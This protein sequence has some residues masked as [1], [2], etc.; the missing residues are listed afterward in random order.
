[1]TEATKTQ[2]YYQRNKK[3]YQKGGKY[4]KYQPVE[5]RTPKIP[6]VVKKG[7]FIISFD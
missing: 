2:S 3:H 1:M 7:K 5:N 6:I 4:Y